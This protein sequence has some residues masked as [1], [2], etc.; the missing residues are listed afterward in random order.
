MLGCLNC[1]VPYLNWVFHKIKPDR[2]L[3]SGFGW[4]NLIIF[5]LRAQKNVYLFFAHILIK[6]TVNKLNLKL[7]SVL[8]EKD[9]RNRRQF[10]ITN[11]YIIQFL[12]I[13]L[14]SDDIK[15]VHSFLCCSK[16]K[17]KTTEKCVLESWHPFREST[18]R[19][20]DDQGSI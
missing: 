10:K 15:L 13:F 16:I 20:R 8:C 17:E 4:V 2:I 14:L 19:D 6:D 18:V 9:L 3:Q 7:A 11:S 5:G 12:I 1:S